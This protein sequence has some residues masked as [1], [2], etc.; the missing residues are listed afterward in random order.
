MN[1]SISLNL[2]FN[3]NFR[4]F[5]P[6]G[7]L[8]LSRATAIRSLLTSDTSES[9]LEFWR[10]GF[11]CDGFTLE[12]CLPPGW[13]RKWRVSCGGWMWVSPQFTVLKNQKALVQ[14]LQAG[15]GRESAEVEKL[16][17]LLISNPPVMNS[18]KNP[19]C[20]K[21]KGDFDF[22]WQADS[23]LP[24]GWKLAYYTPALASMA[25]ARCFKLLSPAGKCL[26]SRTSAL[27]HMVAQKYSKKTISKM[28]SGLFK[29]GFEDSKFLPDGWMVRE[30]TATVKYLFLSPNYETL[31]SVKKLVKY[32]NS[33]GLG[34][35]QIKAAKEQF[36]KERRRV[37]FRERKNKGKVNM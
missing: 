13:M 32:M 21:V 7:K 14:Y 5:S 19:A 17:E 34:E 15:L 8:Y 28:R 16:T 37:L 12:S 1:R 27:R 26:S 3:E 30:K 18:T 35:E 29:D 11:S 10:R 2:L 33:R 4:W 36:L 24:E 31:N 22:S 6:Q 23:S 20:N 9:E 25:A